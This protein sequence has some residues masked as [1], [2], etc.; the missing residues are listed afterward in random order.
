MNR[1]MLSP[2]EELL[3]EPVWVDEES[4][5]ASRAIF[6]DDTIY[7]Q[8]QQQIFAKSWLFLAH[9][10]EL[11]SNGDYVTRQL[12][13][14]PVIVIRGQDGQVRAF[15]NSCSHRGTM[16]CRSDAGFTKTLRCPYHGWVF[17]LDGKLL[18]AAYPPELLALMGKGGEDLRPMAKVSSYAGL[19]FGTWN[20]DAP[21]L[22]EYLG[23]SKFYIDLFAKRTPA[24]MEVLGPPQRWVFKANWKLGALNF[25][26]DGPHAA[27][28]HGPITYLTL[29]VPQDAVVKALMASPAIIMGNGHN[30]IFLNLPPDAPDYAGF[31]PELV[32]L[33]KKTL[34]AAQE[35][36]MSRGLTKVMTTFPN[37]S[38]VES[39]V[40]FDQSKPPIPF[41]NLRT[42]QPL[43]AQSTEVWNWL[44]V[45]KEA[46][47]EY[48]RESYE[49]GVRTFAAGGTFDQDDAEAWS[50]INHGCRGTIGSTYP[51]DFRAIK[52]YRDR[53]MTDFT[54]PGVA[55]PS[56]YSEMSE[57]A[58]LIH[59]QKMMK[60]EAK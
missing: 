42:W 10:T 15:H 45:E 51:V 29:S 13:N 26:A 34:S 7:R 9:E 30:G 19:I 6:T 43:S 2:L 50:S 5:T 56:T 8:E 22:D 31:S 14:D 28:V 47:A 36:L 59:W 55:Y 48:K 44:L 12:S 46:A 21:S 17:G 38:W 35:G 1:S 54:G 33:Y 49:M 53:P 57:F 58:L 18:S 3:P 27:S 60:G 24:G 16:L 20:P 39:S 4:G 40:R 37:T 32:S 23:E 11:P 25:A 52:H 41:C